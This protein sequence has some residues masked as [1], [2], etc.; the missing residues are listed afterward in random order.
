MK[1]DF[2]NDDVDRMEKYELE[3]YDE[4]VFHDS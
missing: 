4:Q 3:F 2:N 1:F